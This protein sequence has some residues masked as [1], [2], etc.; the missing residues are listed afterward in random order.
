M[1]LKP[2]LLFVGTVLQGSEQQPDQ[3]RVAACARIPVL[4]RDSAAAQQPD[5]W[6]YTISVWSNEELGVSVSVTLR[7]QTA[8]QKAQL[9]FAGKQRSMCSSGHG[10]A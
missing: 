7:W 6:Y 2:L 8:A 10:A 3:W 1:P 9:G 5:F 4:P